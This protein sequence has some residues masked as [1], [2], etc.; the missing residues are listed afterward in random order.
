MMLYPDVP[1]VQA[2]FPKTPFFLG[3]PADGWRN[4]ESRLLVE[5]GWC[6]L[7]FPVR[8]ANRAFAPVLWVLAGFGDHVAIATWGG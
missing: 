5:L 8:A 2:Y 3:K 7:V 4:S 1:Q 6:D